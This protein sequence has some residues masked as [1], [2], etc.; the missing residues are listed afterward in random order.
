MGGLPAQSL[1]N[2][3]VSIDAQPLRYCVAF[4]FDIVLVE[5]PVDEER[6]ADEQLHPPVRW[7]LDEF[8]HRGMDGTV[9]NLTHT[10]VDGV[11]PL[12]GVKS[13]CCLSSQE[14]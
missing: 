8:G 11:R 6:T 5:Y 4:E 10:N 1:G 13:P 14:L 12:K 2:D 3:E 9:L 7:W